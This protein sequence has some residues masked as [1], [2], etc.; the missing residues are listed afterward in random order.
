MNALRKV[1]SLEQLL[2]F[3]RAALPDGKPVVHCH[4]FFD[5]VHQGHIHHLQYA[6]SLGDVL[7]V[8]V[9]AD[10][11]VNKGVD[12]PLITD[13]LRA[14]SLAALE[15]VDAVYLNPCPTAVELLDQ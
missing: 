10:T 8:S 1:C 14:K 2:E 13:D 12:R 3:R 11:H 7:V 4:G 6:R 15:C 5:I 9:S